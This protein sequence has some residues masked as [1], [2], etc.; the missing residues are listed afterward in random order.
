MATLRHS[1]VNKDGGF[2][3]VSATEYAAWIRDPGSACQQFPEL[4]A[5]LHWQ[6]HDRGFAYEDFTPFKSLSRY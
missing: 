6:T 5:R 2:L 3:P 1:L 4:L